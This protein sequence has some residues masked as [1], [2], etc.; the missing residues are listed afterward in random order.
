MASGAFA[1]EVSF[2]EGVD[3]YAG[4]TDTEIRDANPTSNYGTS[5]T[6]SVHRPFTSN[7]QR[8][9]LLKFDVSSIPSTATVSNATLTLHHN[10]WAND[11]YGPDISV[12][13]ACK[14]WL[15]GEAT[16][17]RWDNA[18]SKEWGS[19]GANSSS[20]PCT[21]NSN[22]G[23]GD[24]R[25]SVAED[26]V[27]IQTWTSSGAGD[28][29]WDVTSLVQDW[30]DGTINNYGMVIRGSDDNEDKIITYD[31]SEHA[32]TAN[33]PELTVTYTDAAS[34]FKPVIIISKLVEVKK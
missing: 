34:G 14:P 22:D 28:H 6:F 20:N 27:A 10:G 24:D 18:N 12:H 16:Y 29:T 5:T 1:T 23:S 7:W 33:R 4:T 32:T 9:G 13:R 3:S 19:S 8:T 11:G 25:D 17:N 2:Q 15:E 30:V 26:T 31:S 21:D